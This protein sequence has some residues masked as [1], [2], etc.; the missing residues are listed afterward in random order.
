VLALFGATRRSARTA[1][2]KLMRRE[3]HAAYAG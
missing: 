3:L 1:S 2:K